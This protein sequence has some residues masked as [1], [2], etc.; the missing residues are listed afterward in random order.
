MQS[1]QL[2]LSGSARSWLRKLPEESIG[3]W[4]KLHDKFVRNFRS[5]FKRPASIEEL[6]ACVQRSGEPIRAYLQRWSIIKNSAE[7]ISDERAI[8]AFNN[9]LRRKDFVEELGRAKPKS[10]SDM[11]DIANKWADG[12]DAVKNKRGRSP[13][14]DRY[15]RSNDRKRRGTRNYDDYDGHSQVAARFASEDNRRETYR[16]SGYRPSSRDE[17]GSSKPTYRPRPRIQQNYDQSPDQILN[18]PYNMHFYVD[19]EGK[20]RS[21]HLMKE[22]RT[23][24]WL[25]GAFSAKQTEAANQ[26]FTGVPG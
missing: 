10:I 8:D 24:L 23:F 18:G 22:C 25:Q 11:M 9:G 20:R 26:G 12:E 17:P 15:R 5:T 7:N 16:S 6:R 14:E 21:N 3:S 2:H 13:E 4:D 19:S 1:L